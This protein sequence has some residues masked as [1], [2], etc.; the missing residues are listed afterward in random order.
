MF[1][2]L[3][4][5]INA[6]QPVLVHP[7]FRESLS[8]LQKYAASAEL[9]NHP[10]NKP[11]WYANVH[12]YT[13]LNENECVWENHTHTIDI[14][15]LVSGTERIRW[16][17]IRQ[18][19]LPVRF[20]EDQDRQEFDA[21]PGDTA[22]LDMLPGMFAVFLPGE[23]HCPKIALKESEMLRKVVIKIPIHLLE[24]NNE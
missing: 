22:C 18:L 10:L 1:T 17:S 8:W 7:A 2:A 9:G 20:L 24:E 5:D 11:G 23:A 12:G 14:Q 4:D 13:T 6:W 19:G 16:A 21:S 3:L 15:Y